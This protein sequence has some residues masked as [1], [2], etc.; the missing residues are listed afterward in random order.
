MEWVGSTGVYRASRISSCRAVLRMCSSPE[1]DMTGPNSFAALPFLGR[2]RALQAWWVGCS[3]ATTFPL[4]RTSAVR[5]SAA[6]AAAGPQQ[7]T[8]PDR[9]GIPQISL[10]VDSG[11]PRLPACA[12]NLVVLPVGNW[13]ALR[14]ADLI[15]RS[16]NNALPTGCGSWSPMAPGSLMERDL[17][18]GPAKLVSGTGPLRSVS[19]DEPQRVLPQILDL[20]SGD[21]SPP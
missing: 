14:R 16:K 10:P 20:A 17:D 7:I 1:K 18:H 4:R 15:C 8:G 19:S 2:L 11:P 5:F 21:T 12:A 6:A 13:L 3:P 9:A